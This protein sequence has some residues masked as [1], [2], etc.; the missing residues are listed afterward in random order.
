MLLDDKLFQ[1]FITYFF[2]SGNDHSD[3]W[4][5]GMEEGGDSNFDRGNASLRTWQDF[6]RGNE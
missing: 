4:F 2:G 3:D 1:H 5:I 6:K